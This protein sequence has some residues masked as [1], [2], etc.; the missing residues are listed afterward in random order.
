MLESSAIQCSATQSNVRKCQVKNTL[1]LLKRHDN[2]SN[3]MSSCILEYIGMLL[4]YMGIYVYV[5]GR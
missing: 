1:M 2:R 5:L 3:K 4:T